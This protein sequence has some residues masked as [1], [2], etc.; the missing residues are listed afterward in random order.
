MGRNFTKGGNLIPDEK[1]EK[2][3]QLWAD[4]CQKDGGEKCFS[5]AADGRSRGQVGDIRYGEVHL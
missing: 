2:A 1:E 4:R 5:F 3:V